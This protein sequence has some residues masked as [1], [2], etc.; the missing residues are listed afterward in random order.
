MDLY[1]QNTLTRQKEKF[2]PIKNGEVGIYNCGPTIYDN[3]HIGNLRTIIF[4]DILRRV[5]EFNNFKV[6]QVMNLTDVDDKTIKKSQ[7]EGVSLFDFT[8]R[9]ERIFR[10]NLEELNI[11]TPHR[12]PR[13]TEFIADM[14]DMIEKMLENGTA[15]KSDDGIYFSIEKSEGYGALAQLKLDHTEKA[16]SEDEYDK[17]NAHD[18][19]LW[20]FAKPEDG[21]NV[22]SAYFGDGRPGWHIEC[23]AMSLKLLGDTFDIH[24]GGEDLIFPHHTNEIAQSEAVTHKHFV[25]YWLHGAFMNV[26]GE[27]MAKSKGNFITLETIA[28]EGFSPLDFR[29]LMLTAHYRTKLDFSKE[30]LSSCSQ[31]RKKMVRTLSELPDFGSVQKDLVSVFTEVINDDFNIPEGLALA[32]K[33]L[34]DDDISPADKKA[35]ILEF[36]KVFGLKL[37]EVEKVEIP[38]KV[39]DLVD[40]REVAR[41]EKDWEEADRYRDEIQ[42]LGFT[43]KDTA[44]GP[45]ILPL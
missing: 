12:M 16:S 2:V 15:Y 32:W 21:E 8:A 13:A 4:F 33:V 11:K 18:F 5:F 36:D 31:A 25:N 26:S 38:Q 24:T 28:D 14:I 35:T 45:Q 41:V 23:S 1:L 20:K 10:D 6:T 40:A 37:D 34:K 17:E 3:P 39:F 27:K 43:V 29:Y 19:A 7:A 44:K 30:S 22:W 42:Q 9:Y